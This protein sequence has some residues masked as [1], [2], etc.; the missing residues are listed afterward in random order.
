M[1]WDELIIGIAVTI[2]GGVVTP[3]ILWGIKKLK[4]SKKVK[5]NL[6][7]NHEISSKKLPKNIEKKS[8]KDDSMELLEKFKVNPRAIIDSVY[9]VAPFLRTEKEA[10][11]KGVNVKWKLSFVSVLRNSSD[12]VRLAFVWDDSYPWVYFD[13]Y[14]TEYPELKIINEGTQVLVKGEINKVDGHNIELENVRL[15]F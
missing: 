3:L 2:I 12:K 10:S 6:I 8:S 4:R 7:L 15:K 9:A 13:S 11:F 14:I 5:E 1:F